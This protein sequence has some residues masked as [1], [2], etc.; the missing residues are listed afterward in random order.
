MFVNYD[1]E[2]RNLVLDA[3]YFDNAINKNFTLPDIVYLLRESFKNPSTYYDVFDEERIEP[4]VDP[5]CGFC[6]VSSYLIYNMTGRDKV[7]Q[8]Y[9][10]PMS[11]HW[12]LY[13]KQSHQIFDI[14]HTQFDKHTLHRQYNRGQPIHKKTINPIFFDTLK[15]KAQI[16]AKCAGLAKRE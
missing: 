7:W 15:N 8:I 16:L 13:H 10:L 3:M 2:T 6:I 11:L 14:T 12:W 9:G 1:I 5:A 4:D